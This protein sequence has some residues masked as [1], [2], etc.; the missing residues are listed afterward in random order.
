MLFVYDFV[1]SLQFVVVVVV[2]CL[3][4]S[5]CGFFLFCLF[6]CVGCV[7]TCDDLSRQKY[8]VTVQT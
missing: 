6:L 3:S 2:V 1:F 5:C 4:F 8:V 7:G